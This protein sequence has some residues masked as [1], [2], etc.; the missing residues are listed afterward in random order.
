MLS[1]TTIILTKNEENNIEK[2]I[3]SLDGLA[4]RIIVVDSFS[5]DNTKDLAL[6]L[7]ADVYENKFISHSNQFNWA[8]KNCNI[9]SEWIFRIDADEEMT[10]ELVEEFKDK[11]PQITEGINGVF[12]RRRRYFMGRWIKH[13]DVYPEKVMRLFRTG[14]AES[15]DRTMDEHIVLKFGDAIEFESDFEDKDTKDLTFW[16]NKHNWYSNKESAEFIKIYTEQSSNN[17]LH[18]K[19]LGNQCERRRWLKN[20]IYYKIPL[21]VRP[22]FYFIYRYFFKLGFLDGKEGLIYH[23]LQAFWY[24]FLVDSKI[25]ESYK[26]N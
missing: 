5:D 1:L 16:I 24:R 22:V 13:G 12:L 20:K 25:Y 19:I 15:E 7:N 6:S 8:L 11:I 3:R 4:E 17:E 23:V 2:C 18:G 26:L 14:T 9:T 21:F 10:A